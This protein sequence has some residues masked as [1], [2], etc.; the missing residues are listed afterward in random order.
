LRDSGLADGLLSAD[1]RVLYACTKFRGFSQCEVMTKSKRPPS[2]Q[3]VA[4]AA[5]VHQTT[6][7]RAL[8]NDLRLPTATRQRIQALAEKLGYRPHPLVS[9]LIALRRSRRPSRT[10]A[11]LAF[12]SLTDDLGEAGEQQLL[13]ARKAAE[14]HG[15]ALERFVVDPARLSEKRLS[16]ILITRNISGLLI[17]PFPQAQGH[18]DFEWD[19]FCTVVLEF[20]FTSPAFDRVV[21]DSYSGMRRIMKECRERGFRRVGVTLSTVANERTELMNV[22]GYWAEQKADNFF[23]SIP[24]LIQDTW[25]TDDFERWNGRHGPEVIVT[26]NVFVNQVETRSQALQSDQTGTLQLI[27]VNAFPSKHVS[28]IVQD[29]ASIGAMAM[30]LLIEKIIR[31]DRGIPELRKTTLT[32]GRWFEGTTLRERK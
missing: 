28:G 6:V 8:R 26:S 18:F 30:S 22:A 5:G 10:Y 32:P 27:N 29:H 13:G 20:T 4:L 2:M 14:R 9:A 7:S 15:Y 25:N 17:A 19:K 12:V 1:R 21:H 11:T 24:P 23:V 31:N 3:D 16:S